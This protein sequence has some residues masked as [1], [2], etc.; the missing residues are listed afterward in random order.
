VVPGPRDSYYRPLLPLAPRFTSDGME[1][2]LG[3]RVVTVSGPPN[4]LAAIAALCD[5][6][7]PAAAIAAAVEGVGARDLAELLA[8][9]A[10]EGAV[11]DGSDAWRVFHRWSAVDSQLVRPVERTELLAMLDERYEQPGA[12]PERVAL[13]PQPT[14]LDGLLAERRSSELGDPPRPVFFEEL[15]ALLRSMYAGDGYSGRPVPSGG[16]LY[17]LVVHLVLPESVGPLAQGAWWY[18]PAVD[19]LRPVSLASPELADAFVADQNTQDRLAAGTPVVVISADVGR[20]ARKYA[21]RAYRLA[22]IEV[23]AAM[24]NA[25]LAAT[26]LGVPIRALLGLDDDGARA[27]LA[28]PDGTVPLLALLVGR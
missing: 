2:A 17:P 25:Y 4:Q 16:G 13:A 1:I 24:Q 28:L 9:L 14:A 21:S 15:S 20:G 22:L 27:L 3:S 7:H 12:A 10:E 11:V 19:A 8:A 23:G 26:D 6:R 18:E 5:G